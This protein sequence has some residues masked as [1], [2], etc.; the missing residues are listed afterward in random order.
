MPA[1]VPNLWFDTAALDAD[2]YYCT[3][4]PRSRVVSVAPYPESA[5]ER[6]GTPL[7]VT[8]ELDGSRFVGIN[9]GPRFTFDEA[10]SFAI[11][12]AD[13]SEVDHYWDA[14]TAGGRESECGWLVDRFGLSWQVVPRRL[15][16]LLADPDPA[17]A[18]RA[19]QAMYGMRRLD[20]AALERAADGR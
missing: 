14:L 6:A 16:E 13:Q 11:D 9:G 1:V 7:S 10:V 18:G 5:G 15:H 8:F 19:V 2:E 4:F 17:R 12:C 3:V 20:V